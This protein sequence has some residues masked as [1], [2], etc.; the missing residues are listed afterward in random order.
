MISECDTH[1]LGQCFTK[2]RLH[3]NQ[4][5]LMRRSHNQFNWVDER[6]ENKNLKFDDKFV[7][8]AFSIFSSPP[9]ENRVDCVTMQMMIIFISVIIAQMDSLR[10]FA[11]SPVFLIPNHKWL[12]IIISL[13]KIRLQ[14][15]TM[16]FGLITKSFHLARWFQEH[17]IFISMKFVSHFYCWHYQKALLVCEEIF[18]MAFKLKCNESININC[19]LMNRITFLLTA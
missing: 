1:L 2:Y 5:L 13:R 8:H 11:I 10:C 17:H 19:Y 4:R 7:Q 16:N 9:P 18:I 6:S 3:R 15:V 14:I 12:L